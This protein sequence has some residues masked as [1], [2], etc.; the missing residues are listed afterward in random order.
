MVH[1][2]YRHGPGSKKHNIVI[3]KEYHFYIRDDRCH[4][5]VYIQNYFQLFYNNLKEKNIHMDQHWIWS[6]SCAG[7]L[8]NDH[9]F[10]WLCT[11]HK[12]IKVPH[13]WNHFES[14]QEKQE[15]D[16]AGTCIKIVLRRR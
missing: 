13:I 2:T 4:D 16:G 10:Q 14:G 15:N 6:Y 12:Q 9:V 1:I 7:Q 8:K 3:L 5:L 11:L